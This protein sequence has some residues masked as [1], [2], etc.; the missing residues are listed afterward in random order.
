MRLLAACALCALF[1]QCFATDSH[2]DDLKED[3]IVDLKASVNLLAKYVA[4]PNLEDS[5]LY[6]K[7][8]REKDSEDCLLRALCDAVAS[9]D[10]TSHSPLVSQLRELFG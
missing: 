2:N 7:G 3:Q 5:E 9:N 10:T 4:K 6:L 8:A 1:V